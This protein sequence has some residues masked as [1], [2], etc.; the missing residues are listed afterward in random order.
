MIFTLIC[1]T[2]LLKICTIKRDN[3]EIIVHI[4]KYYTYNRIIQYINIA[5]FFFVIAIIHFEYLTYNNTSNVISISSSLFSCMSLYANDKRY[6]YLI[7]HNIINT[8]Y[9]YKMYHE[10]LNNETDYNI[11]N[12]TLLIIVEKYI[13]LFKSNYYDNNRTKS[14]N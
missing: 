6:Y 2:L 4:I 1:Y 13:Y 9:K 7:I 8:I 10:L 5:F 11:I 3:S 12:E 14:Y